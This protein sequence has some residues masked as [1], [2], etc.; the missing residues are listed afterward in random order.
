MMYGTSRLLEILGPE[1]CLQSRAKNVFQEA[2]IFEISRSMLFGEPT[3]LTSANW[4]AVV[5]S[6]SDLGKE[7]EDHMSAVLDCMSQCA[8]LCSRYVKLAAV[9]AL[10]NAV[11]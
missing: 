1:A 2:R 11:I 4:R 6:S 8:D 7:A 9:K 5:E 3:F 10:Q